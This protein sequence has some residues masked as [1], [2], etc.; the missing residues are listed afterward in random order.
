MLLHHRSTLQ[1]HC[2]YHRLY[3][4]GDIRYISLG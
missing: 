1:R 2:R 3:G 4:S